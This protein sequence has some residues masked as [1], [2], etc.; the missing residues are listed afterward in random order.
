MYFNN[1]NIFYK[2]II[3]NILILIGLP[4]S[5]LP[6]Q[7][8]QEIT[9]TIDSVIAVDTDTKLGH[10]NNAEQLREQQKFAEAIEEYEL[11]LSSGDLCGKESEAHYCIGICYLW[12]GQFDEAENIFK[13]VLT[14]YP[15]DSEAIAF[16]RYSLSWLDVQ[17]GNLYE[18]IERLRE[19]LDENIYPDEEFCSRAQFQIGR[20]YFS[21][22]NDYESAEKEF[23]ILLDKYPNSEYTEHPFVAHLKGA[24]Q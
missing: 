22:L 6:A 2:A 5:K 11:V 23:R 20:I 1:F 17:N 15:N 9:V 14:T 4:L 3:I 21:Y 19:T 24:T 8:I 16:T 7:T 13:E 10:F 12:M 18:A